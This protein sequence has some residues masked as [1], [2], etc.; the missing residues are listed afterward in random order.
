MILVLACLAC[1]GQARRVQTP[2]EE[3][4]MDQIEALMA[5][6]SLQEAAKRIAEPMK[7]MIGDGA[8][9]IEALAAPSVKE[10]AERLAEPIMSV[11]KDPRFQD[12]AKGLVEE[13]KTV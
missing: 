4:V 11:M 8:Q 6:P 5:D 3:Q 9:F 12:Q 13:V 1:V 10:Q 2:N 7:A